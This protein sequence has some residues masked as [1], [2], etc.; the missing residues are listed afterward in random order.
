MNLKPLFFTVRVARR[1]PLLFPSPSTRARLARFDRERI[2]ERVAWAPLRHLR[3]SDVN[4][5][6][7]VAPHSS[8]ARQ[9]VPRTVSR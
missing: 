2:P 1:W 6:P 9:T 8:L 3:E 7:P 5:E 4:Y